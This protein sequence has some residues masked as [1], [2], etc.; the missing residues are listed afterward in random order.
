V[1]D[2][3]ELLMEEEDSSFYLLP[4]SLDGVLPKLAVFSPV[5]ISLLV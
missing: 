2:D 5:M 1:V 4:D 3:S